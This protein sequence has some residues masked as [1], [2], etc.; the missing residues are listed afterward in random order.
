MLCKIADFGLS[1]DMMPGCVVPSALSHHWSCLSSSVEL[2]RGDSGADTRM[3]ECLCAGDMLKTVCGTPMYVAPE[4]TLGMKYDGVA[5]DVWSLGCILLFILSATPAFT[6]DNH[7][8]PIQ[9]RS[10]T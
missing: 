10:F 7:V 9:T 2:S 3:C 5:V 6:A 8:G 4:I 1:N